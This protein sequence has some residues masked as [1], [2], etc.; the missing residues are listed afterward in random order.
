MGSNAAE[1]A[2]R[3]CDAQGRRSS[4][5][6]VA[7]VAEVAEAVEQR[8]AA[9]LLVEADLEHADL[10]RR[11]DGALALLLELVGV[12]AL[13]GGG[14]VAIEL[15]LGDLAGGEVGARVID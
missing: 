11:V 4:L 2:R 3:C 6:C 1:C 14:G 9:G 10:A 13:D 7:R 8:L 15:R 5:L 12:L